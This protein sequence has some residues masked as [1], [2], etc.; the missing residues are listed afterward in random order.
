MKK[1]ENGNLNV[2]H[3][4]PSCRRLNKKH[5]CLSDS[6]I[7]KIVFVRYEEDTFDIWFDAY[8]EYNGKINSSVRRVVIE[9]G[10]HNYEFFYDLFEDKIEEFIDNI[11]R[12]VE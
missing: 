10:E 12:R 7:L 11:R 1:I 8:C 5:G 6:C 3:V 4:I 2:T 9:P